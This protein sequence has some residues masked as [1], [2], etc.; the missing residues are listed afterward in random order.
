MIDAAVFLLSL[1][2]LAFEVQLT[3]VFSISQWNHLAFM[4]ISIALFG[5]GAGGVF[6]RM[7]EA[8][9]KKRGDAGYPD[10]RR[11]LKTLSGLYPVSVIAAHLIVNR[12]PL[13]YF[14]L[15]LE[16]VQAVYIG[17]A[18][19]LFAMP[20]FVTGYAVSIAYAYR[21]ERSGRTY[22]AAMGGSAAGV[23]V[24]AVAMTQAPVG[25]LVTTTAFIPA[26]IFL[27][28]GGG[29]TSRGRMVRAVP[30]LAAA[31]LTALFWDS[32]PVR[33]SPYKGMSRLLRYPDTRIT[34]TRHGVRGRVDRVESP[35]IR[36]APGLS[37]T[38]LSALPRGEAVFRDADR[39]LV[40]YND[41]AELS[42]AAGTLPF[43]GY[44][45]RDA[46][47]GR[48]LV[49]QRGGGSAVAC[50][51]AAG[52]ESIAI[53]ETHPKV[54]D[55]VRRRYPHPVISQNPLVY[56]K[57]TRGAFD[58]IQVENWGASLP[59]AAALDRDDTLTID[60][61]RACLERLS[62]SGVL[63]VSR[64]LTL[65]PA[66]SLR[67]FAAAWEALSQTGAS[68]PS[69]HL[70][71][72]R[73]WDV[74]TLVVSKPPL[75]NTKTARRFAVEKNFDWLHLP[76]LNR[77]TDPVNRFNIF[78]SPFHFT[79]IARLRAAYSKGEEDRF[80]NEYLLD[81]RP[82]TV[83]RPFPE[84][85]LKWTRI[86]DFYRVVGS[87]TY[88]LALSGEVVVAVVLLEGIL[89]SAFLLIVPRLF[90]GAVGPAGKTAFR[91]MLFFFCVGAGYILA[92]MF[93]IY[94]G[95]LVFGDPVISFTVVL[96][97]MLTASGTGGRLSERIGRR[98][99]P[100]MAAACLLLLA[101]AAVSTPLG[102]AVVAAPAAV[103][104]GGFSFGVAAVGFLLGFPFPI[105]M[106]RWTTS[107][108]DRAYGWAVN[109]CASVLGS[110]CAAWA[111]MACG[112]PAAAALA[113]LCYG[114]GA[115]AAWEP[116]RSPE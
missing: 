66:G 104:I 80:F 58:T 36:F 35:H 5:F 76:G 53:V 60:A 69:R 98:L 59:G 52:A 45:L 7:T 37:L 26:L 99:R 73:N 95:G 19:L 62:P 89:I 46:P 55:F 47:P 14:R 51:A 87:R 39:R 67:L 108:A 43:L 29:V 114:T 3:R 101:A 8:R 12:L 102:R 79:Q 24:A 38:H 2:A 88:A 75:K 72:A 111:M 103:R 44:R 74:F 40:L 112:V 82:Q 68:R 116:P 93:L 107:A 17:A 61:L 32:V 21:P 9:R 56:L 113:A 20:F 10:D 106:G 100:W 63:I 28:P 57:R 34:A 6:T 30:L 42:F 84:R 31:V 25:V 33:P 64:R 78:D 94:L 97:L 1:S 77:T 11:R 4:V 96:G 49:I 85:F 65:P 48:A 50:A 15:V 22:W 81:V 115:L 91:K 86:G 105:A 109:G 23:V 54:A 16:P 18:F 13:D 110:I 41:S 71:M 27:A 83:A 70:A 92:E 90:G